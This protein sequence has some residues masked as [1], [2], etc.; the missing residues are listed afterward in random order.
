M[1]RPRTRKPAAPDLSKLPARLEL[2][3]SGPLEWLIAAGESAQLPQFTIT[4]YT[5]GELHLPQY[6]YPVVVDLTGVQPDEQ[7][8]LLRD[9]KTE[10]VVGHGTAAVTAS[11]IAATGVASVQNEHSKEVVDGAR[12]GFKWQASIGGVM[13]KV[14]FLRAGKTATV[15][16]RQ[17]SGPKIIARTFSL[18]EISLTAQGR[19]P[20]TTVLVAADIDQG[21]ESH[22]NP[23]FK[24]W[25]EEKEIDPATV[26][27]KALA[28]LEASY[29]SEIRASA[30][31]DDE[32][33]DFESMISTRKDKLRR[34]KAIKKI[35]ASFADELPEQLEEIEKLGR[36]AI[37][38]S[39]NPDTFELELRR[40]LR[41]TAPAQHASRMNP[42]VSELV[43]QAAV[44]EAAGLNNLDKHFSDQVLQASRDT[45][46]GRIGLNQLLL[47]MARHNG[48]ENPYSHEF[49]VQAQRAAFGLTG[50][51][52]QASGGFS[53]MNASGVLSNIANKFLLEGWGAGDMTWQAIAKRKNV[54]DFKTATSYRLGGALTYEK[55]GPSGEITH[56]QYTQDS[57]TNKAETY[58]RMLAITRTDIVNDDLDALSQMPY[59]LGVAGI[60]AFNDIFWAIFLNN[61]T[62]FA[63]G[64]NNVS[65]GAG[66]ALALAGLAAAEA[67]FLRQ[68]KPNGKPLAVMPSILLVPPTLKATALTLMNS[69]LTIGGSTNLPDG[70]IWNGRFRVASAP[71]MEN[72]NFTGYSTAAWYLLASPQRLATIEAAFLNGR[73]TPFIETAD[74]AFNV[75]G[76][77]L[78]GVHDFGVALQEP[79]AG[80]RSAGS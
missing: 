78:R 68:T 29:E 26:G 55:V 8:K 45:F 15:N 75:L 70:N 38:A 16:G 6:P 40:S 11:G 24:A 28:V 50:G 3:A 66:S 35:V 2:T 63:S 22:M 46:K 9:H 25:L 31:D 73:E 80:V 49:N 60:D 21:K 36:A 62:F 12:N 79:R 42:D 59:E 77:Q 54:K 64:N 43:L 58:G 17:F 41:P 18:H 74:A 33:D 69:S 20:H 47:V 53:T 67:V 71:Y 39:T 72:S 1:S 13:G 52:I 4:A 30:D 27:D 61:S 57:Y 76:I 37:K 44:C 19:D 56:G 10:K 48:Y 7:I 14:Q 5:G 34:E 23:E 51:L 65:T 32:D